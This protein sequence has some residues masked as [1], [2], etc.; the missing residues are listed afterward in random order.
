MYNAVKIN[1]IIDKQ[2]LGQMDFGHQG[3]AEKGTP[4]NRARPIRFV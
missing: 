1:G 2:T 3:G 4:V